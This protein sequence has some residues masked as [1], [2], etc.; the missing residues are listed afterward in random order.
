M[1]ENNAFISIHN[2]KS[3]PPIGGKS[4]YK[5][6]AKLYLGFSKKNNADDTDEN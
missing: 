3:Q 1:R 4:A 5:V 6:L 2:Y